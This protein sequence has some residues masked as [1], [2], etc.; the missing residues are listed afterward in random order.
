MNIETRLGRVDRL[1]S[2][3]GGVGLIL[4]ALFGGIDALW[5]RIVMIAVGVVFLIGFIGGI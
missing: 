3:V 2:G 1:A 4:F 5:L